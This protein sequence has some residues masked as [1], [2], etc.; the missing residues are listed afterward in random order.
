M[1]QAVSGATQLKPTPTT[2]AVSALPLSRH[3]FGLLSGAA[4]S[5]HPLVSDQCYVVGRGALPGLPV[6]SARLCALPPLHEPRGRG[7]R[8]P[9]P[10]QTRRVWNLHDQ[11][12]G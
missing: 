11:H 4:A 10:P 9:H 5:Q 2:C 7:T 3:P 8:L 12:V 6:T 1:C